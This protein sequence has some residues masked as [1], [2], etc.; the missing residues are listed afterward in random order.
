MLLG[1]KRM[2][3]AERDVIRTAAL[4]ELRA[5]MRRW[6]YTV[7][8]WADMLDF[9]KTKV[10]DWLEH[11]GLPQTPEDAL[12]LRNRMRD[13]ALEHDFKPDVGVSNDG[14]RKIDLFHALSAGTQSKSYANKSTIDVMD[15]GNDAYRYGRYI[16]D[17]SMYP[18]LLPGDLAVFEVRPAEPDHVVHAVQDSFQ[19]TVKV[20]RSHNSIENFEPI[21]K[22][23]PTVQK[24]STWTIRGVL[25]EV[26]R[27][28]GEGE[29][30][31]RLFKHGM[32][33]R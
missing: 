24:D 7:N 21:N 5:E 27:N 2:T 8:A 16:D 20:F 13:Y 29:E 12:T 9:D 14:L 11:R 33:R 3:K 23:F 10:Y 25:M 30:I 18:E 31:I 6:G 1:M 4:E 17:D 32:R 28:V 26:R 22:R 15:W 19:D